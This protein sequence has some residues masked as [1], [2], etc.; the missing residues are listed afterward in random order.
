MNVQAFR[1]TVRRCND[2]GVLVA[3]AYG[4]ALYGLFGR[5]PFSVNRD[6]WSALMDACH[7]PLMFGLALVTLHAPV[8]P[9][10]T[11][12]AGRAILTALFLTA[13]AAL[14]E[15][16]QPW[17]DRTCSLFDFLHGVFGM[18][19]GLGAAQA[20]GRTSAKTP[21][22][23]ASRPALILLAVAGTWHVLEPVWGEFR[24][25]AWRWHHFPQLARFD[26]PWEK[27]A[28]RPVDGA[29]IEFS[30]AR[31]K[32]PHGLR[33]L[34]HGG[35]RCPG[36]EDD[37]PHGT[38]ADRAH[39]TARLTPGVNT[40]TIPLESLRHSPAR[41]TLNLAAIRRLVFF[42]E[43]DGRAGEFQLENLRLE[44]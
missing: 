23:A 28:W 11:G 7:V 21:R 36:V 43:N 24:G 6:F 44:K 26:S 18:A 9:Q 17:F 38:A 39:W 3:I 5:F 32:D 31:Q 14:T 22:M 41:R 20:W 29:R 35:D 13:F 16:V 2:S 8:F 25:M 42:T 27:N 34:L 37:G 33:V 12:F 40:F 10:K 4:L 30:S 15:I 19:L 1:A